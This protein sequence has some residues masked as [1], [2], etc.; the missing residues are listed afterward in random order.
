MNLSPN[1][2]ARLAAGHTV[3]GQRFAVSVVCVLLAATVS[4]GVRDRQDEAAGLA[5]AGSYEESLA[6]LA[7]LRIENPENVSLLYDEIVIL[8]WSGQ[9]EQA[10][11]AADQLVVANAPAWVAMTAGKAARN[12]QRF[13]AA[14]IWYES[15]TMS[16][17][18][19]LDARL[20]LSM[21]L[22]DAGKAEEA[23]AALKKTPPFAQLK[24]PVLLTSAYLF[25]REGMFIPAVNEY[26]RVL[27]DEPN[28]AEA[29]R[30]KAYALQALLL[31]DEALKIVAANRGMFTDQDMVRL[32]GDSLA[33]EL[34]R[35]IQLPNQVYPYTAINLALAH[36]DERLEQVPPDSPLAMQLRYDRVVGRTEAYRTLEAIADYEAMLDEGI[37]P[38]A[39]VHFAA[40]RSYLTRERPEEA[41]AALETAEQLSPTDLEIQI[42]KFYALSALERHE[43]AIALA[44][45]LVE[46]LAPMNQE[47]GSR[48]ALP[49]QT[50]TRARIIAGMGRAYADQLEESERLLKELLAEAPNNISARYS[51]GNI[52]RYRGWEDRPLP[53]Y[54]QALTMDPI[55]LPARTSY[56]QAQIERQEYPQAESELRAIQ[57]S[58]PS[59]KSIMDLNEQWLLH[60]TWQLL[61]DVNWG[62]SSGDTFGSD[63]HQVNARLYSQ[64]VKDN[65]RFYLRTFDDYA[66]FVDGTVDRRRAALGTEYRKGVWT[67]S[68][69]VSFDRGESGEAG[70]AGRVNYRI[71]DK[72]AVGGTLELNSYATQLRAYRVDIKSNL[73]LADVRYARDELYSAGAAVAL[74]D[75]DDGNTQLSILADSRLRLYNGFSYKLDG[76]ANVGLNSNSETDANTRYYA[77]E[78]VVEGMVG[79][80]NTWR[81]YRRYDKALT[82]R[83]RG[84]AGINDQKNFGSDVIWT[85][86]YELDWSINE[87]VDLVG[88]ASRGRRYYDGSPEDQTFFNVRLNVRF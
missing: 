31:P 13:D 56:A 2:V 76:L 24:P 69:E 44:D 78:R 66:E 20:G 39:Y 5:R 17:P 41:L 6:I 49:N 18:D 30:G 32:Q 8:A 25:Q 68:G 53:E 77:P 50:R 46:Q 9:Y 45:S 12:I 3:Y 23:R 73:L 34:R 72:W 26:D 16:E 28:N 64:P 51:L 48:V 86:A 27:A 40:A 85:V 74:Q 80:E 21:A 62:E 1:A 43:E 88:G 36:I 58:H 4:A 61:I 52:Y 7:E 59:N 35:A 71:N 33:L 79:V 14:I 70:A 42:E 57:P 47:D 37:A 87:S 55:L 19:N 15:A 81:Q 67:A 11:T 38:P 83:L 29:L 82:H 75:Y 65:Y 63:Q 10:L 60:N 84:L 54:N 22:A